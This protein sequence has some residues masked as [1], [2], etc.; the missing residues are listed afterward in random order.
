MRCIEQI[1]KHKKKRVSSIIVEENENITFGH[2]IIKKFTG[3]MKEV[4]SKEMHFAVEVKSQCTVSWVLLHMDRVHCTQA[5]TD[6]L[7]AWAKL[8]D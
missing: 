8:S 1:H 6:Y 5:L 2:S 3:I 4:P 7:A